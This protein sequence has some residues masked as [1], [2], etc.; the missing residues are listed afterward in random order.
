MT[1]AITRAMTRE[2]MT[3]EP[4]TRERHDERA[5]TREP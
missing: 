5:I 4:E 1:R 2:H 3:R